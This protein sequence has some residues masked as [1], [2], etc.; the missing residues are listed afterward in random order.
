MAKKTAAKKK[1]KKAKRV[2]QKM[3]RQAFVECAL[4]AGRGIERVALAKNV[5]IKIELAATTYWA[6]RYWK[7]IPKGLKVGNWRSDRVPVAVMADLLGVTAAEAAIGRAPGAAQVSITRQ[8]AA[9]AS[10]S[11]AAN[12]NCVQAPAGSGIYCPMD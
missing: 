8:D 11:V 5:T 7:S 1:T 2:T 4:Y 6:E 10:A 3:I 9:G 12:P